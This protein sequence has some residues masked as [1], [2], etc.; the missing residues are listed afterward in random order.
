MEKREIPAMQHMYYGKLIFVLF[1]PFRLSVPDLFERLRTRRRLQRVAL[2]TQ[3]SP[4][5]HPAV[6]G[7]GNYLSS[8]FGSD[9]LCYLN[10]HFHYSCKSFSIKRS[11][12]LG[13]LT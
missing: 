11:G 3:V 13:R 8:L 1:F 10:N 7:K 9:I 2:P 5:M 6:A 12:R 4:R